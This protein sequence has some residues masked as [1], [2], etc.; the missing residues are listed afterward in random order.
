M[1]AVGIAVAAIPEGL[2]AVMTITLAIGVQRMARRNAIIRRL[3]AVETLGSVTR[4]LLGQDRHPDPQ[5]DDGAPR[6]STAGSLLRRRRHRLPAARA[7]SSGTERRSPTRHADPALAEIARA[8]LLCNDAGLSEQDG[9]WQLEGD[10]TDGALLTLALKT[11]LDQAATRRELAARWTDPVRVRA[12]VHGDAAPRF[13][14][15]GGRDLCQGRS[16]TRR[17]DGGGRAS[18][19]RRCA[20]RRRRLDRPDR[21]D[22]RGRGSGCWRWRRMDVPAEDRGIW[23]SRDVERA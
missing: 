22:R 23:I 8:A 12:Q 10:P 3:P 21:G 2:P 6:S 20:D 13:P 15:G 1:A 16:G 14:D 19:R 5:R 18:C 17:R 7:A 4:H 11:G 9:V